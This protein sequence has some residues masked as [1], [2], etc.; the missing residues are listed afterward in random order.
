MNTQVK[1]NSPLA[2]EGCAAGFWL[3]YFV[4]S[5]AVVGAVLAY[6]LVA[7]LHFI[8]FVWSPASR[9]ADRV[10]RD[11][12]RLLMRLQP[13]LSAEVSLELSRGV[14]PGGRGRLLVSNHRSHL[15]AFILLSQVPGIRILAKRSLFFVPFLGLMMRLSRQIPVRR[16]D[17]RDFLKAMEEVKARVLRGETVH[18]FPEMTRC[19]EG[20]RGTREFSLA[21]FHAA[22]QARLPVVPIAFAGTDRAWPKGRLG[23]GFR[24]PVRV[25]ALEPLDPAHFGSAEA[26][27]AEA[28]RRIDSA[29]L[30]VPALA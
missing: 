10:M 17:L 16:G 4:S 25:R 7:P 2:L 29:L 24:R 20:L 14:A 13:W 21:P 19:P 12:I 1:A 5:I 3:L 23:L 11:G 26:L 22:M 18:V 28:R 8:G 9:A 15:D 27:M 30:E 6:G